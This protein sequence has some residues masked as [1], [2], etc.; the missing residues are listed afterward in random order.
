MKG[1]KCTV[2]KKVFIRKY[3]LQVHMHIHEK[4]T[5][6]PF[7]CRMCGE[8]FAQVCVVEVFERCSDNCFVTLLLQNTFILT[9]MYANVFS[10][11][12]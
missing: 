9:L 10:R 7:E 3:N 11:V 8:G 2:C 5:P 6:K 4:D 12:V 1:F